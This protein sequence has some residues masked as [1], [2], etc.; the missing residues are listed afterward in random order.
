MLCMF[1]NT[2]SKFPLHFPISA[3]YLAPTYRAVPLYAV[4][5]NPVPHSL[6][7]CKRRTNIWCV[8]LKS[9]SASKNGSL[10]PSFSGQQLGAYTTNIQLTTSNKKSEYC[11]RRRFRTMISIVSSVVSPNHICEH[12][13][14]SSYSLSYVNHWALYIRETNKV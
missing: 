4:S 6:H 14:W 1:Q 12:T 11:M 7:I 3:S 13:H 9:V 8:C 10:L 5:A 2:S